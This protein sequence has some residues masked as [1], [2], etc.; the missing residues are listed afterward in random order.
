[1][2]LFPCGCKLYT[3]RAH[4]EYTTY[5]LTLLHLLTCSKYGWRTHRHNGERDCLAPLMRHVGKQVKL[6]VQLPPTRILKGGKR[7]TAF[8]QHRTDVEDSTNF[9]N[10]QH[11]DV[12]ITH[13]Q[14]GRHGHAW[15][16]A[17]DTSMPTK[18]MIPPPLDRC[19]LPSAR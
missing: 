4:R 11:Y 7:Q 14:A 2:E 19:A 13:P 6:E 15:F 9:F 10:V 12:G 8:T 1:M 5:P 3:S 18:P 16:A 17:E